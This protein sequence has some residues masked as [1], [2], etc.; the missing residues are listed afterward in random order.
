MI[1]IV[2]L[3]FME[4]DGSDIYEIRAFVCFRIQINLIKET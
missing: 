1:C 2:Y 4:N 3:P